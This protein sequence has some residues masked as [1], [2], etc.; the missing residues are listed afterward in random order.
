MFRGPVNASIFPPR[1]VRP[2]LVPL[3]VL[4]LLWL[5]A[6]CERSGEAT[7]TAAGDTPAGTPRIVNGDGLRLRNRPD[8]KG[9]IM[10]VLYRGDL[11]HE[12]RQ[13]EKPETIGGKTAPWVQIRTAEGTIG[14]VF[15]G[16]LKD[17]EGTAAARPAAQQTPP[18]P[19]EP[20]PAAQKTEE[21]AAAAPTAPRP[22]DANAP[23]TKPA[24]KMT[25]AVE[26]GK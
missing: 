13:S 10:G 12:L 14:W 6:V 3:S 9:A 20:E 11:V 19:A 17:P 4:L 16:F 22:A 21:P 18:A 15:G 23:Q 2:V 5:V 26:P 25:E 8:R 1:K 24:E 7:G